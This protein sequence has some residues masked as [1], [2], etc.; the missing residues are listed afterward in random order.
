MEV[1]IMSNEFYLYEYTVTYDAN[2]EMLQK[3]YM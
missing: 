3:N 2:F 1:R